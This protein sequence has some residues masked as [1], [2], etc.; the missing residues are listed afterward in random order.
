MPLR[1][2]ALPDAIAPLPMSSIG[3]PSLSIVPWPTPLSSLHLAVLYQTPSLSSADYKEPSVCPFPPFPLPC[4]SLQNEVC[5]CRPLLPRVRIVHP[6]SSER[7]REWRIWSCHHRHHT[8]SVS[9]IHDH[10][11]V[12]SSEPHLPLSSNVLQG[13]SPVVSTHRK[14]PLSLERHCTAPFHRS[15]SPCS[16]GESP[17]MSPYPAGAP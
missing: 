12:D 6:R 17:T 3:P 15:P 13:S 9:F 7:C 2:H 11:L 10:P 5:R 1:A 16:H 4:D 8:S 14:Q